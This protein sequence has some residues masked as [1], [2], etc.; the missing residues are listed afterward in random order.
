MKILIEFEN[1]P[2]QF[3]DPHEIICCTDPS[4]LTGAFNRIEQALES[5]YYVAGFLSYEAG[6]CFEEVLYQKKRSDFPLLMMGV[7]DAPHHGSMNKPASGSSDIK[8]PRLNISKKE[9]SDN[10]SRIKHY[11]SIGD[12]YQITYCLKMKFGFSGDPFALYRALLKEQPVPYGAYIESEGFHILSLSP[13]RFIKKTGSHVTTE[14]MKGTWMRGGNPLSD[15]YERFR[16]SRDAKNR[17]ENIMITDLLRNDLGRVG[18]NIRAPELFKVTRYRTLYQMTSI[19]TGELKKNI[20]IYD[21]FSAIFPSGSVTVAPKIRSMRIIREIENEE[22]NIYTGA[23]GYITPEKD[24][25]FNIPIRTIL[26]RDG[27]CEMGIGGGIVWDSTAEGEWNE[28]LLKAR[29]LTRHA[30]GRPMFG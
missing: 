25:Y 19:V 5:G 10:I 12:T 14:P 21:L 9:Y 22:R 30:S 29:F 11:I 13:E 23:I 1:K 2:L 7:Y 8:D 28:G 3:N 16:F 17:A 6:H 27:R 4:S 26:I 20:L 24:L 15:V 18:K